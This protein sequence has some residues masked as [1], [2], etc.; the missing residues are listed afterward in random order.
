MCKQSCKL[1]LDSEKWFLRKPILLGLLTFQTKWNWN[2]MK[3][4][5]FQAKKILNVNRKF[6]LNKSCNFFSKYDQLIVPSACLSIV[7]VAIV[8]NLVNDDPSLDRQ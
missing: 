1:L 5:P 8:A 7:D 6:F 3:Y 2:W 4:V